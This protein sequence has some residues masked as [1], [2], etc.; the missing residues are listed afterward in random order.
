VISFSRV[1]VRANTSVATLALQMP[2]N[3]RKRRFRL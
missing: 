3:P 1:I 2:I